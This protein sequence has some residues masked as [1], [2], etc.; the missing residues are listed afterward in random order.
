MY[1]I[2]RVIDFDILPVLVDKLILEKEES[3]LI[4]ILQLL[5]ILSEGEKAPH[6]L[7]ATPVLARL[8]G[9]LVSKNAKIRELAALN[10]GAIS[11][12]MTGKEKTIDAKSI[13]PLCEMLH[14]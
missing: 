14:D 12:N 3:I 6:I 5:K 13:P 2:D 11:Y 10:L 8:N 4:L 9:H 1:G 7:L